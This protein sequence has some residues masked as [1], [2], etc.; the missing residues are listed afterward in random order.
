[1]TKNYKELNHL[2]VYL[3]KQTDVNALKTLKLLILSFEANLLDKPFDINTVVSY[4]KEFYNEKRYYND[5][6]IGNLAM[7]S[8]NYA[9]ELLEFIIA[10]FNVDLSVKPDGIY[11]I[12][13]I[14]M[15][16]F[17]KI[18][19]DES[20]FYKRYDMVDKKL[21]IID[22]VLQNGMLAKMDIAYLMDVFNYCVKVKY[23]YSKSNLLKMIEIANLIMSNRCITKNISEDTRKEN[24]L[25]ELDNFEI[26]NKQFKYMSENILEFERKRVL[27][28]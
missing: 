12:F 20:I 4:A 1:M 28:K 10:N 26:S 13:D 9:L 17:V 21:D 15:R 7:N 22:F 19:N 14:W 5:T 25:N 2:G 18:E 23:D 27:K 16:S 3:A 11:T 8:H 24:V 6:I